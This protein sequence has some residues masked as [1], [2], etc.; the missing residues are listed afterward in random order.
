MKKLGLELKV[1]IFVLIALVGLGWLVYKA[2]DFN[3]KPGY[4]IRLIFSNISGVENGSAVRLAG[5]TVGQVKNVSIVRNTEGLSQ[6]EVTARI[7]QGIFIEEDAEVRISNLGLLGEKYIEIYPGTAG[8]KTLVDGSSIMGKT[9]I[10]FEK[11]SDSGTRLIHKFEHLVDNLDEFAGDNDFK[12][13]VKSTFKNSEVVTK[14]ISEATADFKE[15]AH[16]MRIILGRLKDGEGSVG[17]LLKDDAMAKDIEAFVKDIKANPW[18]L[19]K[20]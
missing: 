11:I 13:S 9:P 19:L 14:N 18:K 4:T 8:A 7:N 1:G 15:A 17:R 20:R 12:G 16:S 2:G 6:V 10:I 3:V 5:V